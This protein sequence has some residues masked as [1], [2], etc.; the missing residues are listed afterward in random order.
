[1]YLER[2]FKMRARPPGIWEDVTDTEKAEREAEDK[3][4]LAWDRRGRGECFEE[5]VV[6]RIEC[7]AEKDRRL[8]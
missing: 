3:E 1:M 8:V 2:K 7:R 4:G 6:S 5:G